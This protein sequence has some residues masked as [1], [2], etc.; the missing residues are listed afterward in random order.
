MH[1]QNYNI[2]DRGKISR[3]KSWIESIL[4]ISGDTQ[5]SY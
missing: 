2:S 1:D 5:P 3:F 4:E